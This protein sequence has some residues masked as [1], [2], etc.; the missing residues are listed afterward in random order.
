L[1]INDD[2]IW[3]KKLEPVNGVVMYRYGL[4]SEKTGT[5]L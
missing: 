5:L 2:D 3:L 4:K 1:I